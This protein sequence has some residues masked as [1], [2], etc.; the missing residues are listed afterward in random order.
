MNQLP[1][2]DAT[3]LHLETPQMPM[4][5][6]AL[7]NF[8]LPAD[9]RGDFAADMRRHMAARLPYAPAL[10]Q[11]LATMPL[12]FSNPVWVDADPDLE[13]HI[14][15]I[16]LPPIRKGSSGQAE[17]HAQVGRLH[18]SLL[19]RDRPLWKF[20]VFTGLPNG[21]QG[22]KRYAMYTQLHHA[23]V[24]GQ[25]A[26]ALA[27][28]ILDLS[29]QGRALDAAP[30]T[31]KARQPIGMSAMLRGAFA[32]QLDLMLNAVKAIPSAVTVLSQMAAQKAG[33]SAGGTARAVVSRLKGE[34]ARGGR[35]VSNLA[36]A[37]RTRL[38]ATVSATR[39]FASIS[40]PLAELNATR[41]KHKASLN[42][43]VLMICSG[44]LRRHFLRHGPLPRKPMVAGVPVS[45]RAKGDTS[46]NNQ[47]TMTVV[48]L[49]THIADPAKRLAYVLAATAAMKSNVGAIKSLMPTDFPTLG[50]PW[51]MQTLGGLLAKAKVAER[52]PAI[53]NV[54]I[55]NVPGPTVP[56]YMAG[57]RMLSN[58]PTS[59]VVHGIA[60]NITVQTYDTSLEFGLIACGEAMPEIAELADDV[61]AAFDEFQRLPPSIA[62][63]APPAPARK[64]TT[65]PTKKPGKKAVAPVSKT[66]STAKASAAKQRRAAR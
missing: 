19:P 10:R 48:S 25:A 58:Y 53:A 14:V 33:D 50:V 29:P 56:L 23:A 43:A 37:P 9:Y 47:A 66:T 32:N 57:A 63:E 5:V 7:H 4:H 65:K 49:G 62:V 18:P 59:I 55:S 42:D 8:E 16:K 28:A 21:P 1:G 20:H 45:T 15:S 11:K 38:N 61:Q 51:L 39:A 35:G 36:L 31:T 40:L 12:N 44:A 41:R 22:Q 27:Q 30:Q 17:L 64:A 52:L 13:Q 24:D 46:S 26:V 3:F 60:L 2:L 54:A 6:G 34:A